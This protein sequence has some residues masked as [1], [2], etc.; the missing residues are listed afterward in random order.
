[1]S[2]NL[3]KK[4]MD[5][6]SLFIL[7][8]G[9][10]F[11]LVGFGTFRIQGQQKIKMVLDEALKA[12]YRSFDTAAVYSNETD[13]GDALKELL[14]KYK[15]TRRDIFLTSKLSPSDQGKQRTENAVLTSVHKLQCEYLDL[16]LIHWPGSSK[17]DVSNPDNMKL[18]TESWASLVKLQ[19]RGMLKS[20]GVSNYTVRH[21]REL[22]SDCKGVMPAVNQVEWHPHYHQD[23]LMKE[24][25]THGILLQAYSSLGGSYN[26]A[27]LSDPDVSDMAKRLGRTVSQVLLRWALQQYIAI[28]PKAES[29]QH[30]QENINLDFV[31]PEEDMDKLNNLKVN[32][33]YA[34]NPD[35]VV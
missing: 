16:F 21:I 10:V 19:K 26:K 3:S 18:R 4:T 6:L 15:L 34:W 22:I 12:G 24:C 8:D 23:E 32:K 35:N 25:K 9:N 7:N 20:I 17:L 31:I 33:K 13:I 2:K 5:P 14:P 28:I 1:M 11:P 30:I 29:A 27:L